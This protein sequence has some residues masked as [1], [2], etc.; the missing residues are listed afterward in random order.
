MASDEQ[1]RSAELEKVR[2]MLFP[3]LD[4]EEGRRRIDAA[5]ERAGEAERAGR[6][7]ELAADPD[8]D[9]ELL[10]ALARLRRDEQT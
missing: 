8:L 3:N 9:N 6:V 4:P 2:L 7:D 5:L 10:R 1:R